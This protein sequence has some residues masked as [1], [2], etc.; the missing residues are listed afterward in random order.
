M[1]TGWRWIFSCTVYKTLF[2]ISGKLNL[3]IK[4]LEE[5]RELINLHDFKLDNSFLNDIKTQAKEK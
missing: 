1:A 2:K 3:Q 4:T 5:N